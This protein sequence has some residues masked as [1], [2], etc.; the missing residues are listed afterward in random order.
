MLATVIIYQQVNFTK[1]RDVGY[2]TKQAIYMEMRGTVRENFSAIRSELIRKGIAENAT[3]S[4]N[5]VL[6]FGWYDASDFSWQGKDPNHNISILTEAVT[7]EY[8]STAGMTIIDGR[9]FNAD[10]QTD[11][12][13][14]I[15]NEA[16][17]KLISDHS[18][19]GEEIVQGNHRM[20]VIGVVRDFVHGNIYR[21]SPSPVILTAN[22]GVSN[23]LR[24]LTIR[25]R[26]SSDLQG[27]LK[28]VEKVIRT[29]NPDYP[30]E[31]TFMDEAFDKLFK[32]EALAQNLAGLFGALAVFISCLGLFGLASYTA[33][34]R[35]KEIGV[36]KILGASVNNIT[37]MI[38]FDFLKLVGLSFVVA[39]PVAWLIMHN[40]LQSYE[41]RTPI[42]WWVFVGVGLVT[43]LCTMLTVGFQTLKAALIN[44]TEILRSE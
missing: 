14:I 30:F 7:P 27:E 15:I 42:Y 36:R 26:G 43:L 12:H 37:S 28:E 2:T 6:R 3:M 13:N 24:I 22:P 40:W 18:P 11:V 35:S 1:G 4:R 38:S 34:R 20:K 10:A 33:Q 31:Y 21:K 32:T 9:D 41:Y 19:V 29:Y 23:F 39:F 25:L 17:A 8:I 44:P 16:F 5:P